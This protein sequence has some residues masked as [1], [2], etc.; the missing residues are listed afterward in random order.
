MQEALPADPPS[1]QIPQ[2][3]DTKMFY[4]LEEYAAPP[5]VAF[6][7]NFDGVV[8]G[9]STG[10]DGG[11]ATQWQLGTPIN[12]GPLAAY[13]PLKC[14]GTNI[15]T[16]Y[17]YNANVWLRSPVL[18]LRAYTSGSLQ[19]QEFFDIEKTYDY[20]SIRV[21]SAADGSVLALLEP[22]I[23]GDS[24]GAWQSYSKALP[25]SAFAQP[26]QIEFRLQSDDYD[27]VPHAGWY[28]DDFVISATAP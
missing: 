12:V 5:V 15:S 25:S 20:G 24:G 10:V 13:S 23:D 8:T 1:L 18:D 28:I 7:E 22:R 17:G 19:F 2:P 27:V 9:W 16:N 26:I 4:V 6:S 14:Y 11:T 21:L 3:A